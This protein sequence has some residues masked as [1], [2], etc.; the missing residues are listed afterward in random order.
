MLGEF[1]LDEK[2][3]AIDDGRHLQL[4]SSKKTL[5]NEKEIE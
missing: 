5:T 2:T 4:Q 3:T 1:Y